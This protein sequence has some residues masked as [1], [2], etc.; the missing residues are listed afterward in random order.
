VEWRKKERISNS[1]V[2]ELSVRK[3]FCF[4]KRKITQERKI[5]FKVERKLTIKFPPQV[6]VALFKKREESNFI[7]A[8]QLK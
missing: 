6:A 3:V 5:V 2:V 7:A 4:K 1:F 8:V